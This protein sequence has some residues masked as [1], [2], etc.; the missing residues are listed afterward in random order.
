MVGTECSLDRLVGQTRDVSLTAGFGERVGDRDRPSRVLGI[1]PEPLAQSLDRSARIEFRP[2]ARD[3]EVVTLSFEPTCRARELLVAALAAGCE[4]AQVSGAGRRRTSPASSTTARGRSLST[5]S[6]GLRHRCARSRIGQGHRRRVLLAG[7]VLL[8]PLLEPVPIGLPLRPRACG[9]TALVLLARRLLHLLDLGGDLA[10]CAHDL[11]QVGQLGPAV[12]PE[13]VGEVTP[14]VVESGGTPGGPRSA[15]PGDCR[16]LGPKGSLHR[17]RHG[18]V[19]ID[20]RHRLQGI[21]IGR[22]H[23]HVCAGPVISLLRTPHLSRTMGQLPSR[24]RADGPG[25]RGQAVAAPAAAASRSIATA[26]EAW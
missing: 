8:D 9:G 21:D 26:S 6:R 5:T 22:A 11:I 16:G 12:L 7:D 4:A 25:G 3:D 17:R 15:L 2:A 19:E 20:V 10:E 14:E 13:D 1:Q 23:I 24:R 18:E